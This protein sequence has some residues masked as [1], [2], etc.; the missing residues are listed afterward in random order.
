VN[1]AAGPR[2]CAGDL[3]GHVADLGEP[4]PLDLNLDRFHWP[5]DKAVARR[6]WIWIKTA[7]NS[8]DS[9]ETEIRLRGDFGCL[10]ERRRHSRFASPESWPAAFSIQIYRSKSETSASAG[11][12]DCDDQGGSNPAPGTRRNSSARDKWSTVLDA[13][14][15]NRGR[16]PPVTAPHRSCG[17][18]VCAG[19]R[20]SDDRRQ[21]PPILARLRY[22]PSVADSAVAG[23]VGGSHD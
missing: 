13:R 12:F 23:P 10:R 11:L 20:S 5:M 1:L 9:C 7:P 16:S 3:Q 15:A 2:R 17:L 4:K 6:P 19:G 8:V 18:H 14:V 21:A 22:L